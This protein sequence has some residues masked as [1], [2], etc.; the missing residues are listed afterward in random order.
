MDGKAGLYQKYEVKRTDGTDAPGCKHDGC[1]YLVLDLTH[2]PIAR[3]VAM[4]YAGMLPQERH[5]LA[6][7][8]RSL[9]VDIRLE[10]INA[11]PLHG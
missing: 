4:V 1:R 7:D 6:D 9:V 3:A 8:L 10:R 2:D 5:Q 11:G